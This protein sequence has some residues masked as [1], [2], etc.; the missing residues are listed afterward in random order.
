MP[1]FCA[2]CLAALLVFAAP[3]FAA[4]PLPGNACTTLNAIVETGGSETSGVRHL[5]RCDGSVWKQ[6]MTIDASGY[7]GIGTPSPATALDVNGDIK[8]RNITSCSQLG[9]DSTGKIICQSIAPTSAM[10]LISTQTASGTNSLQFTSLPSTWNTIFLSCAGLLLSADQ[11]I[12]VQVG[13]GAGPTWNTS[14]RYSVSSIYTATGFTGNA[15]TYN[16]TTDNDITGAALFSDSAT[17][18]LSL[19]MYM[20]NISSGSIVKV[21]TFTSG[22][23]KDSPAS[24]YGNYTISG[25][26]FW[27]NDTNP[28]TAIR[29]ITTGG[30]ITSGTCSLY[31]MN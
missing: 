13:A 9:T 21:A 1:F 28:V 10:S 19:K 5:L 12:R 18:P 31:G 11:S 26:G 25:M 7:V 22:G 4:E 29:L 27:N 20:D 17:N 14:G 30:N 15:N 8:N 3:S 2:L 16:S 23:S 24:S 6:E